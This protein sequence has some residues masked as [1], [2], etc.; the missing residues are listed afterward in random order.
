M[1]E[2]SH[3]DPDV[4]ALRTEIVRLEGILS[5]MLAEGKPPPATDGWPPSRWGMG[6]LATIVQRLERATPGPLLF[7]LSA[8]GPGPAVAGATEATGAAGAE[9]A[10]NEPCL[11]LRN[12]RTGRPVVT[13][14]QIR[15]GDLAFFTHAQDDVRELV[16]LVLDA[17]AKLRAATTRIE[18]LEAGSAATGTQ[19]NE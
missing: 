6:R 5:R 7:G 1:S 12:P 17:W 13:M 9:S 10:A 3:P 19:P 15:D 4:Q 8:R 18:R 2:A 16:F 11:A 14:S